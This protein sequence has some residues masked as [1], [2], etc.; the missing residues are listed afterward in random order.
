MKQ[1]RYR[2][3]WYPLTHFWGLRKSADSWL[4]DLDWYDRNSTVIQEAGGMFFGDTKA[5]PRV[6]NKYTLEIT[7]DTLWVW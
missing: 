4:P 2:G 7:N 3:Y 1:Q 6:L 5:V